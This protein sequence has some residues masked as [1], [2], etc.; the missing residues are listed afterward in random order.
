MTFKLY[1]YQWLLVGITG[2][3]GK[4]LRLWG[5]RLIVLYNT[6]WHDHCFS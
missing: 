2:H 5:R 4:Q 1:A 6:W 3:T